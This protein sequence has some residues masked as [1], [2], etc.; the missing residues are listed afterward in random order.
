ML[1]SQLQFPIRCLVLRG[2]RWVAVTG[3]AGLSTLASVSGNLL[4]TDNLT[5]WLTYSFE[6][7][8]MPLVKERC[9]CADHEEI[10]ERTLVAAIRVTGFWCGFI[11]SA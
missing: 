3:F 4:S 11:A 10:P 8:T 5:T 1:I 9:F 7:V 6:L 2:I